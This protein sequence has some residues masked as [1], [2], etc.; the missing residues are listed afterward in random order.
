M[1]QKAFTL[2]ELLAVIVVLA[3]IA[4]I[5]TPII[6]GIINEVSE[7]SIVR[8]VQNI[9]DGAETFIM[10]EQ[11]LNPE[12]VFNQSDFKY[13]GKQYQD[14]AIATNEKDQASVAVYENNKCYYILAGTTEVKVEKLTKEEC[15]AKVSSS[16]IAGDPLLP[17]IEE[18]LCTTD[19]TT[20]C[21]KEEGNEYIYTG[22]YGTGGINWLWYGGHQ[23]R[24][25]K[26]NKT[27]GRYTLITSYPVTS[28]SWGS[29]TSDTDNCIINQTCN[30]LEK[31]Y[32]GDWLNNV[33]VA[34]LPTNVQSKLENM[35]YT[36][37]I[38]NGSSVVEEEI[39]N[40][41]VRLLTENEYTTYGGA[42]S[43]LDIKD[44]WWPADIYSSSSVRYVIDYGDLSNDRPS[45]EF[46]VRAIVEISDIT[47]TEGDGS[48]SVPYIGDTSN[49]TS[50]ADASVGEYIS[51]P[52]SDG[53]TYLARIVKHDQNGTKVILNGLYTTSTFGSDTTFSTSSNIYTGALTDFKNTLDSNYYDSTN[54]NFNMTMY[55]PGADYASTTTMF[56]G[57]IGLPSVGE[58]FSGNDIDMVYPTSNPKT[59]V[60]I[61]KILNPALSSYYWLMNAYSSSY[62]RY[63]DN[64]GG[65]SYNSPSNS[66]GVRATWY[67]SDITITGG[68]GTPAAPYTL[69]Q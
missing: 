38:Y 51:I 3:I 12:Y 44:W 22:S 55:E 10:S 61:S 2:I 15:L 66:R 13:S 31:S 37:K 17:E 49:A 58:M 39:S 50:V 47:I 11:T 45:V 63:V 26:V 14:I 29:Y 41:K 25:I 40:V 32:V 54:R 4:L 19:V 59:F 28:I 30:S 5:A 67:I 20:E 62:V 48:L 46:G 16:E 65:L 24:I 43:Y 6:M 18:N 23:W 53:S 8:S 60:D 27:I 52:K 7:Q 21:Y 36:R 35:T 56:T 33:F 1:K 57:N 68:N 34:S 42:D 69:S 64:D 9:Q